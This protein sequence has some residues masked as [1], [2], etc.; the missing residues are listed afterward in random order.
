MVPQGRRETLE[1]WG[2]RVHLALLGS[3]VPLGLLV[4]G[5]LLVAWVEK[6]EK[7]RKVPRGNQVLMGPQGGQAQWGLE[8]PLDVLGLR[9]FVGSPDLW[10]NQA[11]WD[12]LDC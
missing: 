12:L 9:V 7:E 11:F 6:A 1:M 2:D 10:V 4:K 3:P 5:V 8:G